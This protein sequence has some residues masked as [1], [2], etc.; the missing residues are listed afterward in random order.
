MAGAL[1][2]SGYDSTDEE[3]VAGIITYDKEMSYQIEGVKS[4]YVEALSETKLKDFGN[5]YAGTAKGI[6]VD[7]PVG[8]WNLAKDPSQVADPNKMIGSMATAYMLNNTDPHFHGRFVG[9]STGCYFFGKA[10]MAALSTNTGQTFVT[11]AMLKW[12]IATKTLPSLNSTKILPIVQNAYH[13][14]GMA[15]EFIG[16][17]T[18]SSFATSNLSQTCPALV[19]GVIK[20]RLTGKLHTDSM[21]FKI[22]ENLNW[23]NNG[24][25]GVGDGGARIGVADS[26]QYIQS[27]ANVHLQYTAKTSWINW[28]LAPEGKYALLFSNRKGG[29]FAY[30]EVFPD[31][32]RVIYDVLVNEIRSIDKMVD[33]YG[34]TPKF[35]KVVPR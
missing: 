22:A 13:V 20:T 11:T 19:A 14:G 31:G 23:K 6:F 21:V 24:R 34:A 27:T 17:I 2:G 7:L 30:G 18:K 26:L 10:G 1:F 33:F 5:A 16:S 35:Y 29:H 25:I 28:N 4:H 3:T 9:T 8:L 32:S 12:N 15:D